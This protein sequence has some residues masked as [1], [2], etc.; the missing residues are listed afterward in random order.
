MS[1]T[2]NTGCQRR[3]GGDLPPEVHVQLIYCFYD[4]SCVCFFFFKQYLLKV[5]EI[6]IK[7]GVDLLQNLIKYFHAQCK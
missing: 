7:K 3:Q 5:N 1:P 6:K 4:I 2:H